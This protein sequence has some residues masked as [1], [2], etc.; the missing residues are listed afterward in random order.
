MKEI[1]LICAAAA[2][3]ALGYYIM[4][5]VDDCLEANENSSHESEEKDV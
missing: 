2:A 3:F 5:K 4:K 1:L